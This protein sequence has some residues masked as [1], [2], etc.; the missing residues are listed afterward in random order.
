MKKTLLLLCA[1]LFAGALLGPAARAADYTNSIGMQF[2]DIPVG[3]FYMGSCWLSEINKKRKFMG[4]SAKGCPSGAGMDDEADDRETPQHEVRI[5]REFRMGVLVRPDDLA[6]AAS[7]SANARLTSARYEGQTWLYGAT[8]DAGGEV[9][10]RV[11]HE[12]RRA[13]GT[14]VALTPCTGAALPAFAGKPLE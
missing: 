14:R 3:R 1:L 5:G 9:Q 7:G 2:K 4:L 13:V 8:L 6:F 11:N 10:L 12:D